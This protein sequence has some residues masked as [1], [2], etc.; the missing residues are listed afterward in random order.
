MITAPTRFDCPICEHR[1]DSATVWP[2]H[3]CGVRYPDPSSVASVSVEAVR[4]FRTD[5]ELRALIDTYCRT[6]RFW[7][8]KLCQLDEDNVLICGKKVAASSRRWL[9][10]MHDRRNTCPLELWP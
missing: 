9:I 3:C 10:E 2:V 7:S 5:A 4:R 8:R 6:C 1:D